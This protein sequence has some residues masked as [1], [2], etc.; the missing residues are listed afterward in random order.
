LDNSWEWVDGCVEKLTP[1]QIEARNMSMLAEM[2]LGDKN[3]ELNNATINFEFLVLERQ[4]LN[5]E[6]KTRGLARQEKERLTVEKSAVVMEEKDKQ[7][8]RNQLN[9]KVKKLCKAHMH[10]KKMKGE[11]RKAR[12]PK[13]GPKEKK[14]LYKMDLS[15]MCS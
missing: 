13:G 7:V 6:L 14:R 1:E 11:V 4:R 5:D 15:N 8:E 9:K 3:K 12:G 2:T 10:A